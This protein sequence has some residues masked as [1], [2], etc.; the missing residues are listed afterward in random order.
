MITK[1]VYLLE[2]NKIKIH[3]LSV[4]HQTIILGILLSIAGGFLDAYTYIGRG[5]VFANA[6]TGNIVLVG[7]D[8]LN[9]DWGQALMHLLPIFSFILGVIVYEILKK[10]CSSKFFL[11]PDRT[12]LVIEIVL[13]FI[14][15]FLPH[16]VPNWVINVTI[17]F[18]TSLQ[19]CAFNKLIDYPYATT[20]CT[21]N[22]RSASQAAYTAFTKK[23]A[24]ATKKAICYFTVIL[25][26]LLGAFI[27]GYLT[28]TIG[29]SAILVATVL[30]I[31]SLLLLTLNPH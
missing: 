31:L 21:G 23:D 11:K 15:G 9:K 2:K 17:S 19:Y 26:F 20:M 18:V 29:N 8:A 25:A 16:T 22:L 27:G 7:V 6:Q 13:L 24:E 12:T 4:F 30:I 14:I 5:G 3:P 1:Y 10:T 28:V